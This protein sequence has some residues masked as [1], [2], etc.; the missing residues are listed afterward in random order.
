MR[1]IRLLHMPNKSL[2]LSKL[3]IQHIRM[4]FFNYPVL[5]FIFCLTA[6]TLQA[7]DAPAGS[8]DE[9][10]IEDQ[11]EFVINKSTNWNDPNTGQA[12]EVIKR[13]LLQTLKDHAIDSINAVQVKL[14]STSQTIITQ[15]KEIDKL[16][17]DLTEIQTS[18]DAAKK[19]KESMSLL[20]MQ[21]SKS[22][23]STLMWSLVAAL[24]AGLL[25]FIFRFNNSN[26]VT[27]A[28]KNKLAEVENQFK[29]HKRKWLEKEQVIK[30]QL[31]DEINKRLG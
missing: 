6:V 31:Q 11:F 18:L 10:S 1:S 23:Y 25:F 30:R 22:G 2:S 15:Q 16:K 28:A 21:M 24:L 12:Y 26:A 29:E 5:I 7:Q 4:R 14:N 9:G 19:E 8:I 3:F 17:S 13:N 20:G 27:K